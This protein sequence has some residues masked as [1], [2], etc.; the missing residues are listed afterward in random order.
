MW[1]LWVLRRR[2]R[3]WAAFAVLVAAVTGLPLAAYNLAGA[4]PPTDVACDVDGVGVSY[5]VFFGGSPAAFRV[6]GATLTDVSPSCSGAT[7]TVSLYQVPP[8]TGTPIASASATVPTGGGS[9]ALDVTPDPLAQD[10]NWVEV[11]LAGGT[12]PDIP[13]CRGIK[14]DKTHSGSK[15]NDDLTGTNFN[16]LMSGNGGN[17]T[18]RGGNNK[19]CLLGGAGNDTLYGENGNDVL[20]GGEGND[21]LYGGNGN[22]ILYGG[23]GDDILYGGAG[24][25]RLDGG[26]GNDTCYVDREDQAP[27]HCER[28]VM[29]D[30]TARGGEP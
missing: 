15:E 18:L 6:S 17:D 28:V 29:G 27:L 4:D 12:A 23:P 24:R 26:D 1:W 3:R 5:T 9:V 22:D 7:A 13:E 10:V 20:L 16:D 19:D 25:D 8:P 14:V 30:P 21:Q 2:L 11:V